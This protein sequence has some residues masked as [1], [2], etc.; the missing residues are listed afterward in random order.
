LAVIGRGIHVGVAMAH[1]P[2]VASAIVMR[3][4]DA[5]KFAGGM[6]ELAPRPGKAQQ[7]APTATPRLRR[8][9]G[10]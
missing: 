5:R 9:I 4:T 8:R 6:A 2:M 7:K 3:S 1:V 10:R